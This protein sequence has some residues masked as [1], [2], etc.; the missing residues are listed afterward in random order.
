MRVRAGRVVAEEGHAGAVLRP[1]DAVAG[2]FAMQARP[3]RG[4]PRQHDD[5]RGAGRRQAPFHAAPR[6]ALPQPEQQQQHRERG[7]QLERAGRAQQVEGDDAGADRPRRIAQDVRQLHP[8]DPRADTRQILLHRALH[9]GKGHADE[10][11]GRCHHQHDQQHGGRQP[12]IAEALDVGGD[13]VGHGRMRDDPVEDQDQGGREREAAGLGDEEGRPRI[14]QAPHQPR[15]HRH[16]R[17]VRQHVNA[18]GTGTPENDKMET[19]GMRAVF[20]EAAPPISSNKSMLGHTLSAAGAIEAV[21]SLLALRD[22]VLPP[23]INHDEP[24]PAITLDV[25]PN[26]ARDG[27]FAHVL[28]NSFGFGGQNVCLVLSAEPG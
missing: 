3:Q 15:R 21:V 27:R 12:A 19:L 6:T 23:T 13:V 2:L 9:E 18:H 20:G 1:G 22:Q 8:A 4:I 14:L 28:S 10:E 17:P 26:A 5:R 7:Q 16:A 25:V 11:G 24:D